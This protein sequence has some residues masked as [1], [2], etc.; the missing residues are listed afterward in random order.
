M[1]EFN[2]YNPTK[3]V[4]GEDKVSLIGKVIAQSGCKRVLL[5]AGGGSI[6][7]NGVYQQVADSLRQNHIA[8]SECWGVRANPTL[9]KV[10]EAV[11]IAK[12]ERTDA[13]LAVGGG[14]VI[15]SG[16]IT[17]AGFFVRDI[18]SIFEGREKIE[19]A[20]PIFTVLTLSA[21]ASEMNCNAV[22]TNEAEQKKCGTGHPLLYPKVS[23][24][25]PKAQLSLPWAQ[26]V[27]GALDAMAHIM[28]Y[29]FMGEEE[30]T[31]LCVDEALLKSIMKA[32]G[33]L[34]IKPDDL[35]ARA[36]L[37]WAVTMG[38]NG[39]SG[40]GLRGGDWACHDISHSISCKYPQVAHGSALGILFPAWMEFVS[41]SNPHQFNRFS[42]GIFDCIDIE[43]GVVKFRNLLRSWQAPVNLREL[44]VKKSDLPV[45]A[46]MS[47][48]RGE[49]GQL[50]KLD[51]AAVE[52]I[53]T[54]AY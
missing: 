49:I 48:A 21:T 14:S 51:K 26:T 4:F 37:A 40:A 35:Y 30:E 50:Q 12:R 15:D 5:L 52:E 25:D 53:L 46:G 17:A 2:F 44:G 6:K 27:N 22:L 13:V 42:R 54:I 9:E 20:L 41:E 18:W 11:A 38:L 43:E 29:Y 31:V 45:L 28:E 34:K 47:A 19:N 39:I 7:E 8:W 32:V 1:I 23:I 24:I 33:K 16:K 10:M 3:L 36:N